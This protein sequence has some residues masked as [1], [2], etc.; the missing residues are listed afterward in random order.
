[1][2]QCMREWCVKQGPQPL[3]DGS[4]QHEGPLG[5][6]ERRDAGPWLQGAVVATSNA[7]T[8]KWQAQGIHSG[9]SS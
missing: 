3:R 6:E 7:I 2:R 4:W 5:H 9:I 8:Q 1:M